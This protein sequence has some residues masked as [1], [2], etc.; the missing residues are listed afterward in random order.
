VTATLTPAGSEQVTPEPAAHDPLVVGV[1][2]SLAS[3]GIAWARGD[4]LVTD[5]LRGIGTGVPRLRQL[6]KAVREGCRTADLV[7]LEGP[8][9][10]SNT[11]GS[12]ERAGLR[13]MVLERLWIDGRF[14]VEVAPATVKVYATGKGSHPGLGKGP[15]VE[16]ATRRYPAVQTGGS[17]NEV[18][19]LWL[20]ALGLDHLTGRHVV[21]QT[22]RR[23]L[24]SVPWPEVA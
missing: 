6:A 8:A 3:T 5:T 15:M 24:A 9:Y 2:L 11:P 13:W 4:N 18:D 23:A 12:N 16:A 17:D 22:H 21:P 14:V 19:A 7:V 20:A 10:G 1:D